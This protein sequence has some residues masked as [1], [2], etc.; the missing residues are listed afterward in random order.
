[1]LL[2]ICNIQKPLAFPT[3]GSYHTQIHIMV[4]LIPKAVF[5]AISL[6]CAFAPTS[7][8]APGTAT[9]GLRP[10]TYNGCYSSSKPL[11]DQGS[12]T[13]QSPGYCQDICV[14]LNKPVMA[15]TG[16]SNCFCG[17]QLPLASSKTS[18]SQ[19]SIPCFGYGKM[20]CTYSRYPGSRGQ[21]LTV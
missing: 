5:T 15:T 1:M 18:D 19:C 13:F 9:S 16:G 10:L 11:A 12:W 8:Q 7:A 14:K 3:E 17:D 2:E 6:Y 20:N 21:M 4:R